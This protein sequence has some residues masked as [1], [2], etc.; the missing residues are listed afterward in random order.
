MNTLTDQQINDLI[1]RHEVHEY[2]PGAIL[3]FARALLELAAK[4]PVKHCNCAAY[5]SQCMPGEPVKLAPAGNVFGL[6]ILSGQGRP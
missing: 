6:T 5:C 3:E 4:P 1:S 2:H